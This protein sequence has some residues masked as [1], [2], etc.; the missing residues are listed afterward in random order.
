MKNVL[1]IAKKPLTLILT[2][3]KEFKPR[4]SEAQTTPAREIFELVQGDR[5]PLQPAGMDLLQPE[6]RP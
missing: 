1:E 4:S 5:R 6:P 3:S 2:I